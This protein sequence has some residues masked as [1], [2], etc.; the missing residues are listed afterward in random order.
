[1]AEEYMDWNV[2]GEYIENCNC[3]LMCP[4]LLGPRH[5]EHGR[6]LAPPTLG[7]CDILSLFH[8]NA[9]RYGDVILDNLNVGMTNHVPGLMCDGDLDVAVYLDSRA[10]EDQRSALWEI[11]RGNQGGP[12]NRLALFVKTW[13]EPRV[14][15]IEYRPEGFHRRFAIRDV[16]E[17]D[18]EAVPGRD[19]KREVLID[20]VLHWACERVIS[21][22]TN[23]AWYRD[24][25]FNWNHAAGTNAHYAPFEWNSKRIA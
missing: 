24:H 12:V 14:A 6:A 13:R 15:D 1:M 23:K 8:I 10:T 16:M 11:F 9:G 18:V 17:V 2:R 3:D 4:C 22:V 19:V 21:A 25:G 7:Y 20:N 5:P